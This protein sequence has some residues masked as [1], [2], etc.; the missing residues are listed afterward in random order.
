[1]IQPEQWSEGRQKGRGFASLRQVV[2][3]HDLVDVFKIASRFS[4][5][6]FPARDRGAFLSYSAPI[7][8]SVS[9]AANQL[10]LAPGQLVAVT[11]Q[12]NI[13]CNKFKSA[14]LPDEL[15][16]LHF[17]F[18]LLPPAPATSIWLQTYRLLRSYCRR[19]WI[20][21][22]INKVSLFT[23]VIRLVKIEQRL[24]INS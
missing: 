24:T 19:L 5:I 23:F 16:S 21:A 17:A 15:S 1:M 6:L 18:C 4:P 13:P 10:R 14:E 11:R 7:R 12:T 20:H 2:F 9:A 8:H 3:H 22:S